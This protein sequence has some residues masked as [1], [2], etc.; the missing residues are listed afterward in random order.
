MKN[1]L[2][3]H[4]E[5]LKNIKR[6]LDIALN[7]PRSGCVEEILKEVVKQLDYILENEKEV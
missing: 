3:N 7:S 5:R 1:R 2:L 4:N 6:Q